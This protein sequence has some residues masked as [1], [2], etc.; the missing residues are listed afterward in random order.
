[1]NRNRAVGAEVC[2]ALEDEIRSWGFEV[3][4]LRVQLRGTC[5]RCRAQEEKRR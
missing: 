1:M 3:K 4:D 5:Q 2:R